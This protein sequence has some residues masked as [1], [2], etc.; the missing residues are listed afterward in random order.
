M[1]DIFRVNLSRGV[2][3]M[4]KDKPRHSKHF[5]EFIGAKISCSPAAPSWKWLRGFDP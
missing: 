4:L 1:M 3:R 5:K 2:F